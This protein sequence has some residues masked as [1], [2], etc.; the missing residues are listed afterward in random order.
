M[1]IDLD[2]LPIPDWGLHCPLCNY[3]LV[4]LPSHRCPE[5]G[6]DLDMSR[7]VKSW[8]RV[9]APW[10]QGNELPLPEWGL[11]CSECGAS[12]SG[13]DTYKCRGCRHPFVP[14]LQA[15]PEGEW[16]S[17]TKAMCGPLWDELIEQVLLQNDVP[18]RREYQPLFET[19]YLGK[20]H[21]PGPLLIHRDFYFDVLHIL[22]VQKAKLLTERDQADENPICCLHC[23]AECPGNFTACWQCGETLDSSREK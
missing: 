15:R 1:S 4:G 3:P 12:L 18:L 19:M 6:Q 5:C 20:I 11:G 13:S 7:I 16:L 17:I 10:Y 9:R 23:G 2:Q 21:E 8:H 22:S 14:P